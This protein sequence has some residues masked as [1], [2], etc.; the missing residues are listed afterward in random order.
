MK[1]GSG[2]VFLLLLEQ[3]IVPASGQA[4]ESSLIPFLCTKRQYA[5]F[6][7]RSKHMNARITSGQIQPAKM[8]KAIQITKES[9]I[10]AI[11]QQQGFIGFTDL[12][13]HSIGK[14]MFITRFETEADMQAEMRNGF[15]QQQLAKLAP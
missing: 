11:K 2:G 14:V 6:S 15:V 9:I 5:S 4:R 13:D 1:V 7:E 8:E 12:I 10:P 3:E